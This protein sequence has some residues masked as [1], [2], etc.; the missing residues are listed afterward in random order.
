MEREHCREQARKNEIARRFGRKWEGKT[1]FTS[2]RE[3]PDRIS[4]GEAVRNQVSVLPTRAPGIVHTRIRRPPEGTPLVGGR[5][6]EIMKHMGVGDTYD[7]LRVEQGAGNAGVKV[8]PVSVNQLVGGKAH[9][10]PEGF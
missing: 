8:S 5:P 9:V 10:Q 3:V 2:P 7:R 4:E 6:K 1:T